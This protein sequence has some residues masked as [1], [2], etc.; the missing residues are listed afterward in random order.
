MNIRQNVVMALC[1]CSTLAL[2]PAL[3]APAETMTPGLWQ[4]T[5]KVDFGTSEMGRTMAM[6]QQQMGNMSPEQRQAMQAMVSRHGGGELPPM[7]MNGDGSVAMPAL[8]S[9]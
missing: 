6:V 8:S 5:S 9:I 4:T 7:T 1:A 3:A 2:A